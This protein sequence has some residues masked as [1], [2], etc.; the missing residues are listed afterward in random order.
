LID[1]KIGIHNKKLEEY[2]D[3]VQEVTAYGILWNID[4]GDKDILTAEQY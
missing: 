1:G 4:D 2:F 3:E